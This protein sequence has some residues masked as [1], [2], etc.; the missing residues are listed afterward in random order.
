VTGLS[1]ADFA[2]LARA[3]PA[4]YAANLALAL[5]AL[6]LLA[7]SALPLLRG[8]WRWLSEPAPAASDV[9]DAPDTRRDVARG[10]SDGSRRTRQG[11]A[12]LLLLALCY[13]AALALSKQQDVFT[14]PRYLFPIYSVTPLLVATAG[15]A[16]RRADA[17]LRWRVVHW[18][19]LARMAS[20]A[21]IVRRFPVPRALFT[22]AALLAVFL[23]SLAGTVALAPGDT[24]ARD[25]GQWIAGRDDA[26]LA[27]LRA[28]Q[29]RTVVSNDYWEGLRLTY[30]SGETIITVM[31]TPQGH[32]GFNRYRPYVVRGLADPRPAYVELTGTPEAAL[33]V[34]RL[35]AG[36]LPGYTSQRVGAF[37]L[38]L[39]TE[40]CALDAS[41]SLAGG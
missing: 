19:A 38:L 31:V 6:G 27:L 33:D 7:S 11:R 41:T 36:A 24:A 17:A 16:L 30:A 12:A 29:V 4:A 3:H 21:S 15:Q 20:G 23:W 5:A 26:L 25:H 13:A 39:P 32:P 1:P 35:R 22:G 40:R 14:A 34:Q 9:A 10:D 18:V 8:E 2:A 37:T 28:H